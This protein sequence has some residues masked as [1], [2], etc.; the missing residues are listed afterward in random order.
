MKGEITEITV[1][2]NELSHKKDTGKKEIQSDL[3]P[4]KHGEE[5][6]HYAC[7]YAIDHD[8][9]CCGCNNHDC[10]PSKKEKRGR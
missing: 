9:G 5:G 10:H 8:L 7:E 6:T 1:N 2:G 4:F 3:L